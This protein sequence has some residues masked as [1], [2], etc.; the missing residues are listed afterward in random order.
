MLANEIEHGGGAKIANLPRQNFQGPPQ[1]RRVVINQ[2]MTLAQ[3]VTLML[4]SQ[5]HRH[6]SLADLE[7]MVLPALNLGQVAMAESKPDQTG[8]RQPLSAVLWA[9]V[10][11]DVD[12]RLTSNLDAPIRLR[13]D[14]WRSGDNLWIA[15]MIGDMSTGH[16]LVKNILET[17]FSG[18]AVKVR[19]MDGNGKRVVLELSASSVSVVT[20]ATA[21]TCGQSGS[22]PPTGMLCASCVTTGCSGRCRQGKGVAS[23]ADH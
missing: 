3:I 15:D 12:R 16:A 17:I 21:E 14:E 1:S 8:T 20:T 6:F 11:A 19:S 10:S 7:W 5:N 2:S 4:R 13:P 22:C 9:S 18:R 23:A